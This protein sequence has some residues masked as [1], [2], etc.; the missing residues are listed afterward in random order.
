[1]AF[2]LSQSA[3][4]NGQLVDELRAVTERAEQRAAGERTAVA[5]RQ[6][7]EQKLLEAQQEVSA[8]RVQLE[9]PRQ[10]RGRD[11]SHVLCVLLSMSEQA[12]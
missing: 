7:A 8:L 10:A 9:T 1:M 3:A 2:K 6:L 11:R 5:A 4:R 12:S